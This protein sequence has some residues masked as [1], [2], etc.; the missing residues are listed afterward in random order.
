MDS[1]V[2]AVLAGCSSVLCGNSFD[3]IGD[4]LHWTELYIL[5][6]VQMTLTFIQGHKW[7]ESKTVLIFGKFCNWLEWN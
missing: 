7:W 1:T 6:S 2:F 3:S 5:I 4:C